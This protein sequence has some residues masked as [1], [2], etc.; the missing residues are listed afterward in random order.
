MERKEQDRQRAIERYLAEESPAAI[1]K[2]L[3]HSRFW[4]YKWLKRYKEGNERWYQDRSRRPLQNPNRTSYEIEEIVKMV[5]LNLYNQDLFHGPQ[6][7]RWQLEDMAVR[8]LPSERTIA[9]ILARH[10]LTH[11]RTGRYKPKG[12]KYPQWPIQKPGEMHQTDYVGPCYL[13]GQSVIRF[14]SLNNVD[15][16]T[17]RCANEP[18]LSRAGQNTIDAFWATWLRLGMPKYQQMD[19]ETAFYGSRAHPR[20]MGKAIRLCLLHG[21]EPCFIPLAEPWRNGVVEKFN[22]HWLQKFLSRIPMH[23]EEELKRESLAFEQRHNSRYRYSKLGGKTPLQS[24]AASQI[25]L[26][27]PP[28]TKPPRDPLPKPEYGKYHVFRF[29]RSNGLLDLFG[30]KFTLPPEATYEYVRATVNVTQQKLFVYLDNSLID[31]KN[32]LLRF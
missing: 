11:R 16:A 9:R 13:K 26:R 14:Y 24:L 3:G 31:E 20:G 1:C 2:S 15:V 28:N 7:I 21:I 18:V 4:F 22:H 10:E 12:K 30:E 25:A 23:S 17:G 19:N 6:A 8:P 5:R 29:V 27:F 32:Y